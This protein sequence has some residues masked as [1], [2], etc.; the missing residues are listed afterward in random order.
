M[1]WSLRLL[2]WI[3]LFLFSVL[4]FAALYI[5]LLYSV[6]RVHIGLLSHFGRFDPF[7]ITVISLFFLG[8]LISLK[9][10]LSI[11]NIDNTALFWLYSFHY[12]CH[13]IFNCI[14]Q[15]YNKNVTSEIKEL[16]CQQ[17]LKGITVSCVRL[18]KLTSKKWRVNGKLKVKTM[19]KSKWRT[20]P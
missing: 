5:L 4:F 3:C 2:L 16:I 11:T 7:I 12:M 19:A 14:W 8:K 1:N 18:I 10:I 15:Y 20:W 13:V 17:D 9:S 6:V